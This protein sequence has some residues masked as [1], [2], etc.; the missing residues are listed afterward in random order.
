[1]KKRTLKRHKGRTSQV[2]RI[3]QRRVG[4]YSIISSSP[5][6]ITAKQI[7]A[8]EMALKRKL[9]TG[10]EIIKRIFA[11]YP[12]TA[13][14]LEVRMGKGKGS[15]DHKIARVRYKSIILEI[16]KTEPGVDYMEML[17]QVSMKL[18]IVTKIEK[19]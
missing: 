3:G 4:E 8:L 6:R 11:T 15:I 7:A 9:P 18:P 16:K 17:R 5:G 2:P 12:V 10:T 14:P 13:K 1:M 19:N